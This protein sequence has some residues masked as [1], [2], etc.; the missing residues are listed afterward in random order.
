MLDLVVRTTHIEGGHEAAADGNRH[1]R[2]LEHVR[3]LA[4]EYDRRIG[5]S[6]RQFVEEIT[7]RR[8]GEPDETEPSLIAESQNAVRIMTVHGAEGLEFETVILPDLA[9]QSGSEGLN[10][11]NVEEPKRLVPTGRAEP[12]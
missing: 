4:F 11:C 10:L 12:I 9:F 8:S 6:V 3:A 5:G 1:L 2:H 7:E